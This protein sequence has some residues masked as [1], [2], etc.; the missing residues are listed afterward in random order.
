MICGLLFALLFTKINAANLTTGCRFLDVTEEYV[1]INCRSDYIAPDCSLSSENVRHVKVSECAIGELF[2]AI[3]SYRNLS[4]IDISWSQMSDQELRSISWDYPNLTKLNL[5]HNDISMLPNTKYTD[6][7]ISTKLIYHDYFRIYSELLSSKVDPS[8]IG[9]LWQLTDM[10]ILDLSFNR[11]KWIDDDSF[12]HFGKLKELHLV[13]NP[14]EHLGCNIFLPIMNHAVVHI[15]W[16]SVRSIETSCL[17]ETLQ[18][19]TNS[20]NKID[21]R[22]KVSNGSED[23]LRRNLINYADGRIYENISDVLQWRGSNFRGFL[24]SSNILTN[25]NE[26]MLRDYTGFTYLRLRN[27]GLSEIDSDVLDNQMFLY[28]LDLSYNQFDDENLKQFLMSSTVTKLIYLE[29][30]NVAGNQ[31]NNVDE[32]IRIM[33]SRLTLLDVSSNYLGK[34]NRRSFERYR[35]LE[36]L[37]LS[38]TNL[39]DIEPNIFRYMNYLIAL[40]MSNNQLENV[41]F[42]SFLKDVKT[43]QYFNIA[44][45]QLKNIPEIIELL[46]PTLLMLDL[47][48][49]FVNT[50]NGNSFE[51]FKNLAYLNMSRSNLTD[52]KFNPIPSNTAIKLRILDVSHNHL[53]NIDFSSFSSMFKS[54]HLLRLDNNELTEIDSLHPSDFPE[55]FY[56]SLANNRFPCGYLDTFLTKWTK[57]KI[58][59]MPSDQYDNKCQI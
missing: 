39:S 32:I 10:E 16:D 41:D 51:R 49:N 58:I 4:G 29:M 28:Y 9:K 40:D 59:D 24:F 5:S 7:G 42:V 25:L 6:Q 22:M 48:S 43:L 26:E 44:A 47:S 36:Y 17:K 3:N 8:Q 53:S 56:L 2:E 54:V 27:M 12:K 33:P 57:L 46:P 19:E 20:E 13:G 34:M 15:S 35:K 50:L 45:N 31:L 21:L 38:N 52:I 37:I 11:I 23:I 55:L 14:I 1:E 18:I 30:L